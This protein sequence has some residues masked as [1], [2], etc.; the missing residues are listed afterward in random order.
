MKH[1]GIRISWL[2]EHMANAIP[3]VAEFLE[4]LDKTSVRLRS[5]FR[6]RQY[7]TNSLMFQRVYIPLLVNANNTGLNLY[8]RVL[9]K[10]VLPLLS[11]F[12][13]GNCYRQTFVLEKCS[14]AA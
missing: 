4:A 7:K 8:F 6:V 2:E 12:N 11:R 1:D 10:A 9:L 5:E 3:T 14:T 13:F